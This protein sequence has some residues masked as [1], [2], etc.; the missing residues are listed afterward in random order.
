MAMGWIQDP[1][2]AMA[3]PMTPE[4]FQDRRE[5]FKGEPQQVSGI[6][7]L[8]RS[9]AELE[10][11][12]DILDEQAA[13]AL[14]F[15]EKP[16][17]PPPPARGNPLALPFFDQT[18]DGP[19]GWRHCQSSS[20]AMNLAF[21]QVPGIRDDLDYLRVVERYGDTTSQAAHAKALAELN[22]PGRFIT[23]CT[24]ERAKAE[25]DKG[26]GLAIGI[27]HKGPVSAPSGG[28]HYIAVRGYDSNGWLVHD[29]YGDLDLIRGTWA[30]EG[31]GA[32]KGLHYSFKNTNPRWL[33]EGPSSG[34]AWLFS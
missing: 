26:Y 1:L 31:G 28:G 18:N 30:K 24:A 32:G 6:W 27:L 22:A 25:I 13:W 23:N 33:P 19:E 20:I 14:K 11:S 16:P 3:T 29:P 7:G 10:G 34:W 2:A 8:Y 15:S 5:A 17:T 21:L 9:I 12:G 4:R